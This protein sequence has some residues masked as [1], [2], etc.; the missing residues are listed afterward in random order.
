M[1]TSELIGRLL[2]GEDNAE[3]NVVAFQEVRQELSVIAQ[4]IGRLFE[5]DG[6]PGFDVEPGDEEKAEIIVF[7]EVRNELSAIEGVLDSGLSFN[8]MRWK[9]AAS[10]S[11]IDAALHHLETMPAHQAVRPG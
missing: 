4:L 6:A 3:N 5:G 7:Q 10:I 11:K 1:K 8:K 9:I 2:E